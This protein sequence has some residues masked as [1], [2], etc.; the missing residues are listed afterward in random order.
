MS[1]IK[2]LFNGQEHAVPAGSSLEDAMHAFA[3]P[4]IEAGTPV[5][6]ALNGQHV[7]RQARAQAILKDKDAV[8]TFEPITGG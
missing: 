6:S 3:G 4:A 8:T 2:I 1:T 5:A 7:A